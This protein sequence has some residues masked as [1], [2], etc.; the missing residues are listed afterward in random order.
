MSS[1]GLYV[2]MSNPD[3]P[4]GLV[5][6]MMSILQKKD[7]LDDTIYEVQLKLRLEEIKIKETD[8][9]DLLFHKLAEISI[10]NRYQSDEAR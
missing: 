6:N 8:Y 7:K 9:L 10:A 4:T 5:W 3:R 2:K 1:F